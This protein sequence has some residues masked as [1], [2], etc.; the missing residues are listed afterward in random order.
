MAEKIDGIKTKLITE[1]LELLISTLNSCSKEEIESI[2][3]NIYLE[4][5]DTIRRKFFDTDKFKMLNS[6]ELRSSGILQ[7]VNRQ[8]FHKMNMALLV[9]MDKFKDE[10]ICK[11]E[12]VCSFSNIDN[13]GLEFGFSKYDINK[14][15]KA[16]ENAKNVE[17]LMEKYKQGRVKKFGSTTEPLPL[18]KKEKD[19]LFK[20]FLKEI[21][22]LFP[23]EKIKY[24]LHIDEDGELF[25]EII[26]IDPSFIL[27]KDE[28]FQK[29]IYATAEKHIYDKGFKHY[30]INLRTK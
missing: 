9:S 16:I 7:E 18:L 28:D 22:E 13:I 20:N 23:E 8:F 29:K 24:K 30:A 26:Y 6:N 2:E 19:V 10:E 1:Q 17:N 4:R 15:K 21:N 12:G 25:G 27:T 5:I 14:K 3:L 11:I